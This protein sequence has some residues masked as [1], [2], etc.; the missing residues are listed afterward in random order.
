MVPL[1]AGR[2]PPGITDFEDAAQKALYKA[3]RDDGALDV[4]AL[5]QYDDL[6][7]KT[8]AHG[9]GGILRRRLGL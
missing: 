7:V 3:M 9:S 4:E 1:L 2:R 8:L 5:A 6:G